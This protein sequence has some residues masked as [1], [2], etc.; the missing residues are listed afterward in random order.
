MPRPVQILFGV[1]GLVLIVYVAVIGLAALFDWLDPGGDSSA[2]TARLA[3]GV[4]IGL[5]VTVGI[6]AYRRFRGK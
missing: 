3:V 4:V 5:A 6:F 1:I 2:R